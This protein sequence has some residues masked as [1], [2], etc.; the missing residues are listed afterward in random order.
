MIAEHGIKI[1]QQVQLLY[2]P[3]ALRACEIPSQVYLL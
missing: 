2:L 1:Q 3:C